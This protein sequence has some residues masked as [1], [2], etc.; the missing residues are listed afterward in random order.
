MTENTL[1][2]K[3][4]LKLAIPFI[5]STVTQPLLGAVGIGIVGKLSDPVYIAGVSVGTVIFDTMY[6]LFGF[7]RVGTTAFSAQAENQEEQEA[8][9]FRPLSIGLLT[10]LL[11]LLFSRLIFAAS[12]GILNPEIAVIEH[13]NRYFSILVFG[14]PFV[15]S[16]YVILGWLMGR[17]YIPAS[18]FMQI[19]G[20]LL[21]IILD[22]VFVNYLHMDVSGVALA[23]LISQVYTTAVGVILM[24]FYGKFGKLDF[25]GIFNLSQMTGIMKVNSDLMLRTACLLIQTNM[26]TAVSASMGTDILSANAI[27]LQIQSVISYAF[28]GLANASSVCAGSA[29]GKKDNPLMRLTWK[30]TAQWTAVLA[31]ISSAVFFIG[32]ESLIGLF[33]DLPVLRNIAENHAL[34]VNAYPLLAGGGLAFYGVFTGSSETKYVRNSTFFSLLV[35]IALRYLSVPIIGNHGIWLSLLMFYFGRTVFLVPFIQR[36][37]Y[38]DKLEKT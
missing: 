13:I 18:L 24:A 33:T 17:A 37:L 29:S 36:T 23:T 20:N 12:M 10:G 3:R 6:W 26:F 9:F 7:L 25:K 30:R 34:W 15:L 31:L 11:F 8:A 19:S 4:Y 27:L 2:H 16:N 22:I 32:K 38:A 1:S 21:N 5:L 14:A 28:D 35:F